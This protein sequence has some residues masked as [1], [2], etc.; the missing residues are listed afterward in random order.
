MFCQFLLY[1]KVTVFYTHIH[2]F[3][4]SYCLPSFHGK[5]LSR[6]MIPF[7]KGT[8]QKMSFQFSQLPSCSMAFPTLVCYFCRLLAPAESPIKGFNSFFYPLVQSLHKSFGSSSKIY[9]E[10]DCFSPLPQLLWFKFPHFSPYYCL[11]SLLY[12][13]Y[14]F[15]LSIYSS[16]SS[17]S[18]SQMKSPFSSEHSRGYTSH[19]RKC[20][21]ALHDP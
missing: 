21:K 5:I 14:T 15:V 11:G 16:C 19:S 10:S 8:G 20:Q 13:D 17:E 9:P 18:Q 12:S 1:S 6:G 2:T 7:P 3:F 4:F